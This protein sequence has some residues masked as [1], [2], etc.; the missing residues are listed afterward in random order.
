M[1]IK[2]KKG[3]KGVM[4]FLIHLDDIC[5]CL[6]MVLLKHGVICKMHY[7][8]NSGKLLIVINGELACSR[9]FHRKR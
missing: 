4:V 9:Q 2:G 6:N 1:A 3:K 7:C 8:G 5:H